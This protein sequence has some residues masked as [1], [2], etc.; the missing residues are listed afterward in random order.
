MPLSYRRRMQG[1]YSINF[2]SLTRNT[3]FVIINFICMFLL[4]IKIIIF[5]NLSWEGI[6]MS[7]IKDIN[8][9]ASGWDKTIG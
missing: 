9:A 4:I 5:T 2:L 6:K 7:D 8:L 3:V 1:A